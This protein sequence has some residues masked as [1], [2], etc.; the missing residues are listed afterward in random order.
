MR[1]RYLN[2]ISKT[3]NIF[4][5]FMKEGAFVAIDYVGR[6]KDTREIFDLTDE[7]LAKKEGVFNEKTKYGPVK[8]AVGAGFVIRGLDAALKDMKVGDKKVVDIEP[9]NGFGERSPEMT[10]LIPISVFKQQDVEP[11]PGSYVTL[12]G[13]TG[14]VASQDGGRVKIDFN[15]P[16]AGKALEYEIQIL[17][18]IIKLEEKILSVVTFLSRVEDGKFTVKVENNTAE[19]TVG[20]V[21]ILHKV[22]EQVSES[23]L[24]W[25]PE[26]TTVKFVD[27]F[28]K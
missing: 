19:I 2:F 21:D 18:E 6:V 12:N 27:V 20:G 7:A 17:E 23:I 28:A 8:I 16:L 1:E 26:I 24:K 25:I 11:N 5:D 3:R 15:H 13:I 10:R 4:S 14:R 9:A 22:K